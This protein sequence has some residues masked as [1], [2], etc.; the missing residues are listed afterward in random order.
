MKQTMPEIIF[1]TRA[2]MIIIYKWQCFGK[3]IPIRVI[4]RKL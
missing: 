2:S 1:E 4:C 3:L